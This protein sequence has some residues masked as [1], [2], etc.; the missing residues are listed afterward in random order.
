MFEFLKS[1]TTLIVPELFE[2]AN[3]MMVGVVSV[4]STLRMRALCGAALVLGGVA[5]CGLSCLLSMMLG[6]FLKPIYFAG[7]GA[8]V[9]TCIGFAMLYASIIDSESM[10]ASTEEHSGYPIAFPQAVAWVGRQNL[11]IQA[12]IIGLCVE[13]FQSS[14]L[15]VVGMA[16]L[17]NDLL[18]TFAGA[19]SAHIFTKTIMLV[20]IIGAGYAIFSLVKFVTV[21]L[22]S[23]KPEL[24]GGLWIFFFRHKVASARNKHLGKG[25]YS[26]KLQTV[27]EIALSVVIA[28]FGVFQLCSLY[29]IA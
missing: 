15:L 8:V 17:S 18:S 14:A 22:H 27:S 13:M 9:M 3:V 7:F 6:S 4:A 20:T 16:A 21:R 23:L 1:F 29:L 26:K 10:N 19:S 25:I 12:F 28:G 2:P 24:G 5:L 11:I